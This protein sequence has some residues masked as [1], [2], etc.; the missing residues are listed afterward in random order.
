MRMHRLCGFKLLNLKATFQC[1]RITDSLL[2]QMT[3]IRFNRVLKMPNS[4]ITLTVYSSN[5]LERIH[6]TGLKCAKDFQMVKVLLQSHGVLIKSI[7]TNNSF[8]IVKD[9]KINNF[10][11][12][13]KFCNNGK[14]KSQYIINLSNF[15]LQDTGFLNVIHLRGQRKDVDKSACLVLIHRKSLIMLGAKNTT[16]VKK[17]VKTVNTLFKSFFCSH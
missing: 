2:R 12:F 4:K 16:K 3:L 9:I 14:I 15:G 6:V 10:V 17:M 5:K 11:E 7:Q 13:A 1:C 8:F